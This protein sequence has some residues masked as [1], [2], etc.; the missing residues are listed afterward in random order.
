MIRGSFLFACVA[1]SMACGGSRQYWHAQPV[2]T[3]ALRILPKKVSTRGK[4]LYVETDLFKRPF[5]S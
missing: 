1:L 5:T 2:T 4:L 3:P